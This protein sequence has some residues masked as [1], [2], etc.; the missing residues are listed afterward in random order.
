MGFL[1]EFAA[2][3]E[4]VVEAI[5]DDGKHPLIV[6]IDDL[7]RCAPP[8]PTEIIEAISILLDAKYCV[9]II[10][11]DTRAVAASI[12]V[13]YKDLEDYLVDDGPG[14]DLPLGY[15]FLEKIVQFNFRVPRANP[16][17]IT[18]LSAPAW[19]RPRGRLQPEPTVAEVSQANDQIEAQ[20]RRR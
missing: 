15:H 7:D 14:E 12:E 19:A 18:R 6:F 10:G 13:K 2:D 9:F 20:D 5:T 16:Q 1:G 17:M 11:M 8:K 3:F 4:R